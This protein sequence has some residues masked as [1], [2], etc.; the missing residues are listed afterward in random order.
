MTGIEK[1]AVVFRMHL[2]KIYYYHFISFDMFGNDTS[3][4]YPTAHETFSLMDT[5]CD[6][7][8]FDFGEKQL[9]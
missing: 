8:L 4:L 9:G 7:F 3:S 2:E 1:K 6:I 5:I